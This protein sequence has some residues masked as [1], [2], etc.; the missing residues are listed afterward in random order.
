MDFKTLVIGKYPDLPNHQK[1]VADFFLEHPED[2]VQVVVDTGIFTS[3]HRSL[4]ID[5]AIF[6]D[7]TWYVSRP[8]RYL[9]GF[10]GVDDLLLLDIGASARADWTPNQRIYLA[11]DAEFGYSFSNDAFV[12][13][14][15]A[16]S[17]LTVTF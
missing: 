17:T 4:T 3:P 12:G 2:R 5:G 10:Y 11:L 13:G 6:A 16:N 7:G 9:D 1:R 14:W 15:Y 8:A